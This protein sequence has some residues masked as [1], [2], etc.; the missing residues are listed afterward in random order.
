MCLSLIQNYLCGLSLYLIT[1]LHLLINCR[2]SLVVSFYESVFIIFKQNGFDFCSTLIFFSCL[3]YLRLLKLHWKETERVDTVIL[4]E[5]LWVSLHFRIMSAISYYTFLL[6]CRDRAPSSLVMLGLLSWR[7]VM[8]CQR[9]FLHQRRHHKVYMLYHLCSEA[10]LMLVESL[11][12][13]LLNSVC[14][15]FLQ[16]CFHVYP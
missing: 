13:V 10:N 2:T 11:F 14:M 6:L 16:K 5:I 1:L 12:D 8:F 4:L 9:P 15:Y 7:D 3:I